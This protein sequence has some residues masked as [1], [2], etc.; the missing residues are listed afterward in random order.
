MKQARCD[1]ANESPRAGVLVEGESVS[2]WLR[3]KPRSS[4]ERMTV[5][6]TGEPR[7]EVHASPTEG[8]ANQACVEFL[9]H[10][11]QVPK[12]AISI[13]TGSRSRRKLIRVAASRPVELANR[14]FELL[15]AAL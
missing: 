15:G 5:D 3:V 6:S 2:F 7:L 12:S 14:L 11:L 1:M 13:A 4:R 10:A 8:K 9:A